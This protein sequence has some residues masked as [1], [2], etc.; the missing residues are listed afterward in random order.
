MRRVAVAMSTTGPEPKQGHRITELAAVEMNGG[1][2]GKALHLRIAQDAPSGPGETGVPFSDALARWTQFIAGR[3]MV[4]HD[5]YEF[6]R[7]LR[8][9]C[10]RQG[11]GFDI[12]RD[13]PVVDTW[14]LV[15]ERFRR[16]WHGLTVVHS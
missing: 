2:P 7:F 3:P 9:E 12:A 6:R 10:K 15:R 4:V 5:A 13:Y 1:A 16:Q 8:A 14:L 11:V